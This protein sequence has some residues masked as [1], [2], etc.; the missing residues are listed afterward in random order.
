MNIRWPKIVQNGTVVQVYNLNGQ[1]V[2]QFRLNEQDSG[3]SE[4]WNTNSLPSGL[5]IMSASN[6]GQNL[7]ARFI[8]K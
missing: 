2:H 5:Y 4:L 8:K 1:Q 7:S 3:T 6:A